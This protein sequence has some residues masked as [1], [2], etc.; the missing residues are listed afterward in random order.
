[1]PKAAM[2]KDGFAPSWERQIRFSREIFPMKPKSISE[3]MRDLPNDHL[4]LHI[5][6]ADRAHVG[7]T[8]VGCE[9]VQKL[10]R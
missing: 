4:G 9:L 3:R 7:A 10:D 5:F 6:A 1:M 8:A 2:N